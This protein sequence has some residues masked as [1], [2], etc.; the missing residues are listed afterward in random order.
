MINQHACS[1]SNAH[2]SH[3]VF[4][5]CTIYLHRADFF[6]LLIYIIATPNCIPELKRTSSGYIEQMTK[7]QSKGGISDR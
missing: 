3:S 6:P 7:P 5:S 4:I 1:V 2:T